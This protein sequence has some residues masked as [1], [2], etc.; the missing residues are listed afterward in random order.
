MAL[1]TGFAALGIWEALAEP[2]TPGP[3]RYA[4][5][6]AVAA[7][8]ALGFRRTYPR[9]VLVSI[10]ALGVLP[11]LA[12]GAEPAFYGFLLPMLVAAYTTAARLP[13]PRSLIV[14]AVG[15][16][17]WL[18]LAVRGTEFRRF[19]QY[20]IILLTVGAAYGAGRV[21]RAVGDRADTATALADLLRREQDLRAREAIAA[22]RER[23][24]R[25]LHDAIAHEVSVMVL[26]AGAAERL[27]D[28][29][30]TEARA[31]LRAVQQAGRHTIE[32]LYLMLGLLRG[33]DAGH[34]PPGLARIADL[35]ERV[36]TSGLPVDLSIYGDMPDMPAPVS[37]CAYRVVQES[38]TNILK[39]TRGAR[40]IVTIRYAHESV[41]VEV[42][43]DGGS[44]VPLVP[45][46]GSGSGLA[47][48]HERVSALGGRFSAGARA[49]G[50]F[51]VDATLTSTA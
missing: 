45:D 26:H 5:I 38:L 3:P 9:V 2:D 7:G 51:R 29:D 8:V 32:E 4:A 22:E 34:A 33:D 25:E 20:A 50:G 21:V 31:S 37:L 44:G 23:L 28:Y 49:D 42:D 6:F 24:A 47:G 35:V 18:A 43:D 16:A 40:A 1:A 27:V 14:P 41:R 36:R 13:H 12:T 48:L 17:V 10:A 30:I 19:N 11:H 39:H 15:G 46:H